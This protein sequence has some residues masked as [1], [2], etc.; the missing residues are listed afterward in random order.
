MSS[1]WKSPP[2]KKRSSET[3][4]GLLPA[5]LEPGESGG[6]GGR[7]GNGSLHSVPG[8][9]D[10]VGEG[11]CGHFLERECR[12][13]GP[14]PAGHQKKAEG[15]LPSEKIEKIM[16]NVAEGGL[17]FTSGSAS[18]W[19]NTGS[20]SSPWEPILPG[21]KELENRRFPWPNSARRNG[22][23]RRRE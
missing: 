22:R 20:R 17:E 8:S 14:H 23:P 3:L 4:D 16:Q 12:S 10:C 18:W 1:G 7:H 21:G 6:H 19:K 15:L 13:P 11:G 2:W 5:Y 9:L